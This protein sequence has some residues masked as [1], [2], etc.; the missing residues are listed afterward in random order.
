MPNDIFRECLKSFFQIGSHMSK[1]T[2][3]LH[4]SLNS[5]GSNPQE[6]F[7]AQNPDPTWDIF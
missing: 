1:S 5:F 6:V 4:V 7:W 2:Q 3:K